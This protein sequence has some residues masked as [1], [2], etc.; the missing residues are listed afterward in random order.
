MFMGAL[1]DAGL[2][3]R[4]LEA[5]LAALPLEFA[6]KVGRVER[7]GFAA[8]HVEVVIPGSR[9]PRKPR[10]GRASGTERASGGG[11]EASRG[12]HHVHGEAGVVSDA[13]D[14]HHVSHDGHGRRYGEIVDLLEGSALDERVRERALGIFDRLA[15]AEAK[16]HRRKLETVHFHEVGMV[17][18]IVDVTAA[19]LGLELLGVEHVTCSAVGIGHGFVDTAHGRLPIPTPATLALLEGVPTVPLDV[20]WETITPTG[21]ALV[22]SLVDEF[23][24]WPV[25]TVDAVGC[26]AGRERPGAIPNV[27]R[28]VLGRPCPSLSRDRI[29][30]IETNLDDLVPEHF[31]HLLERLMESGAVDVSLQHVVTKKNRPGFLV[32]VLCPPPQ[33]DAVARVLFAESTAIGLRHQE[34][35][36]LLLARRSLAVDTPFGRIRVKEISGPEGDVSF[37]AEYDDCKAAARRT[38]VPLRSVVEQAESAARAQAVAPAGGGR[39]R[40]RGRRA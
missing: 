24:P 26:G 28:V 5:G 13:N 30:V 32:R 12:H 14:E 34:W 31:E 39:A 35:D 6:L 17:D 20:A 21:A 2:P 7:G 19:A 9:R 18:A 29:A 33:R 8:R 23:V 16:V 25:I 36:R 38:G 37:S 1:L 15:R 40:R 22:A 3:R 4:D 11:A 10:R 27:V